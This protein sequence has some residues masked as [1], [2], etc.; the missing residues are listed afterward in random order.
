LPEPA[1]LIAGILYGILF[2]LCSTKVGNVKDIEALTGE[3]V[4]GLIPM[5]ENT[6]EE[7][8]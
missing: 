3:K 5:Q 6:T 1:G 2:E 7:A 8:K 4:I